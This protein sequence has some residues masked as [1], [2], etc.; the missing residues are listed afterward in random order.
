MKSLSTFVNE[1]LSKPIRISIVGDIMQHDK[2]LE[3]E[4]KRNNSYE[5]VISQEVKDYFAES[6]FVVG[7][8]ETV[9][10]DYEPAGFPNFSAPK[11][12]LDEL[13]RSGFDALITCNNHTLDYDDVSVKI[14]MDK[15][16]NAG[17]QGFG[18]CGIRKYII[19]NGSQRITL[20]AATDIINGMYNGE[21]DRFIYDNDSELISLYSIEKFDKLEGINIAIIHC[22]KE[23]SKKHTPRQIYIENQLMTIGFNAVIFL[24]SH[25]I[26]DNR[27]YDNGQFTTYGLG[28]FL[29]WQD[30]LER[31]LG[32]ILT[33][34]IDATG[35]INIETRTTETIFKNKNQ[36]VIFTS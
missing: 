26:G 20:H 15:I 19:Q 18:T 25:V 5:N 12:L 21:D 24:H 35:I 33:L 6:N 2:Q 17:M 23:Y 31:Q 16:R 14:T 10:S 36:Q 34:A 22:G 9:I 4:S 28:N 30:N 11:E 7:N 32:Q 8:L 13:K 3:S 1:N 27:Q 29:S